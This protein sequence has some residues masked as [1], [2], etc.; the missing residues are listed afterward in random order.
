MRHRPDRAAVADI[1]IDDQAIV[2]DLD[3]IADHCIRKTR[4][5]TNNTINADNSIAFDRYIRINDGIAADRSGRGNVR[6]SG[7]D[8]RHAAFLHQ[9]FDRFFV[10]HFLDR[11]KL[12]PVVDAF[13]FEGLIVQ[14]QR[15]RLI[16]I[17]Q[18]SW[19]VS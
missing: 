16:V 12:F 17:K 3:A 19:H 2:A 13:D 1:R 4:A 14:K 18:K 5:G 15:D 11:R 6:I 7:V 10:Y 8:E 9:F